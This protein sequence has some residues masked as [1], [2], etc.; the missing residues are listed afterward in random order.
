MVLGDMGELGPEAERFH[1]EIGSTARAHGVERL[2]TH[3]PLAATAAEE[4]GVGAEAHMSTDTLNDALS[5][6]LQP[7]VRLLIKGSRVNRLERVVD[8]MCG[9]PG[10]R[11]KG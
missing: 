7:E 11:P 5:A 2:F 3:G 1:R 9:A 4:F 6:A 8:A 10:A